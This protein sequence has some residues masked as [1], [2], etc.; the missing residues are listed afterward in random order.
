MSFAASIKMCACKVAFPPAVVIAAAC[1]ALLPSSAL[2]APANYNGISADGKVAIF[3]TSEQMVPGDTD[4]TVDIFE[5]IFEPSIG[6]YVTRQV[7]IGPFGGNDTLPATF[8]GISSDG[9]E[10]FF[11]TRERLVS[12]DKDRK[13]DIYA[14]NLVENKTYL[15]SQGTGCGP[16]CGNGLADANFVPNGVPF[17]GGRVFFATTESLSP[18]DEDEEQDIYVHDMQTGATALVSA[19]DPSCPTPKCGS[20]ANTAQFQGTDLAGDKAFFTTNESLVE[21]DNDT[22]SDIYERDLVTAETLLVSGDGTCPGV[23]NCNPTFRAASPDGSHVFFESNEQ[24]GTDSDSSQDVYDWSGGEPTLASVGATGANGSANVIFSGSSSDGAAVYFETDDRLDPGVDTDQKQDVYVR[25]GGTTELVSAGE[26]GFGNQAVSASFEW[27]SRTGA[28]GAV[29]FSTREQLTSGDHDNTLDVY[30]RSGGATTLVSTG[31]EGGDGE[32]EASFRG[33]SQDGSKV[34]FSTTESLLSE[35]EDSSTDIYLSGP[36]GTTLVSGGQIGGSGAFPAEF[37]A[38]SDDGG[39]A[40]F[41]TQERLAVND[42]FAGEE[43]VYGW[44]AGGI[45]LISAKNAADLVLGPPPPAL[46]GTNPPSP[47]PSTTPAV[48]GQANA[49]AVIKIYATFDCSGEPV[50]SGTTEQLATGLTVEVPVALGSTTNYRAT[51]ES[52]GVVSACSSPISYRQEDPNSPGDGE[53]GTGGGTGESSG[54]DQTGSDGG[55]VGS[56]GVAGS[57]V[58]G[59]SGSTSGQTPRHDGIAYLAPLVRITFGPGSKTRLRRP[60]FRFEDG[61]EQPGTQFLC[62]VDKQRW[63]GCSSPVKLKKL[64]L[65]RHVFSLKAVNAV[66]VSSGGAVKRSFKV[67]RP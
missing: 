10:V 17:E 22:S 44:S 13:V 29:F 64:K 3:S 4:P 62:K 40:F 37:R 52:E 28:T 1:I 20:L 43:D 5:R 12:A 23:L 18:A 59:G 48:F 53:T 56:G 66:G 15:A 2:A 61:V 58:G 51:A 49:G 7:S 24:L 50:V 46:E 11:S 55:Q 45:L 30:K 41:N 67:V 26:E 27:A 8:D 19:A 16:E 25:S 39:R 33:A 65:G 54:G 38:V 6:E 42:D 34:F 14:R 60:V 35:D 21:T 57:S 63:A 47:N 36:A 9:S 31:P 32:A